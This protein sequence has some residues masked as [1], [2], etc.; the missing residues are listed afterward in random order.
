MS[1]YDEEWGT[2]AWELD[3]NDRDMF[4]DNRQC[5]AR[6]ALPNDQGEYRLYVAPCADGSW[7][8]WGDY[9]APGH[10]EACDAAYD[11]AEGGAYFPTK[12][13]AMVAV[14]DWL[15]QLAAE[16]ARILNPVPMYEI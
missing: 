16:E 12:N 8:T 2:W 7:Y 9:H 14:Y 15:S 3:H 10:E 13:E 5:I 11:F 6:I 4:F 1:Y